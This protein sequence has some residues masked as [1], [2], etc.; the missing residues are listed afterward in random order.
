[1]PRRKF[2]D[3]ME[4]VFDDFDALSAAIE[5][6]FYDRSFYEL[7][8]RATDSFF[9]DSFKVNYAS[10]TS[11][12][13]NAGLG[14]Q[15]DSSAASPEPSQRPLYRSTAATLNLTAPDGANPR[16]DIVVCK[17]GTSDEITDTRN[18]K[19]AGTLV[20]SAQSFVLQ[21]DKY[22]EL[23][24][25]TGTPAGSPTTPAT[26]TGYIKLA[27]LTVPAVVGMSGSGNVTDNRS[28]MPL[29]SSTT[30]NTLGYTRLTAGAAVPLST[31]FADIEAA[32]IAGK[33]TWLDYVDQGSNP[34][35]PASGNTRVFFKA[36][37]PFRRVN[38]GGVQ[39]LGLETSGWTAIVGAASYCTHATLALAL[40][41]SNVP[42]GS[43]ILL[44][45]NATITSTMTISKANLLIEFAPGVTYT[46][47]AAGTCLTVAAGGTRIMGG[48][49][50]GFTT[51]ISISNTFNNNFIKNCRFASC[52]S[53]VT[54]NNTTPNNVISDNISE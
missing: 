7:V 27:T 8:Q 42:A 15:Y 24:V 38:A 20:V 23:L 16:I 45:D 52:T 26:P 50:S 34:A 12:T 47:S 9:S 21:K 36:G 13:V 53:D 11:V 41:D 3:G 18:Y 44:L 14:M 17:Y 46:N 25:V 35:A 29:G 51:G 19:D 4:L 22:A 1:M 2:N 54:D 43:R 37:V 49:F 32:L 39:A 30:I 10:P 28:L 40:A 6:E 5:R 48:R 31:L 33:M